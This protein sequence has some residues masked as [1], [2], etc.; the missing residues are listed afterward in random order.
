MGYF[1]IKFIKHYLINNILNINHYNLLGLGL[2]INLFGSLSP[3]PQCFHL[4]LVINLILGPPLIFESFDNRLVLPSR[5]VRQTTDLTKLPSR[6][7]LQYTQGGGYDHSLLSV[8][9]VWNPVEHL[10]SVEGFHATFGFVRNHSPHHLEQTLARTAEV[11]RTLGGF[12]VHAL[13][14]VL[15]YL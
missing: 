7:Q 12:R 4:G 9:R 5:L 1:E 3:Q 15:Q 10:Q 13:P 14:Q 6:F 11:V 2:G 8:V